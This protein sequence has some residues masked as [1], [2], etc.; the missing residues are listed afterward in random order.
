MSNIAYAWAQ[1]NLWKILENP[2]LPLEILPWDGTLGQF[3]RLDLSS[4]RRSQGF[5][6]IGYLEPRLSQ[7]IKALITHK[8]EE[9]QAATANG[10]RYILYTPQSLAALPRPLHI[11]DIALA[12]AQNLEADLQSTLI[13]MEGQDCTKHA[14]G[15]P[16]FFKIKR[17]VTG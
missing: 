5:R 14:V 17:D 6:E 8:W 11:S 7:A 9:I 1:G 12:H 16:T 13:M 3:R 4:S 2:P 10:G 15:Q